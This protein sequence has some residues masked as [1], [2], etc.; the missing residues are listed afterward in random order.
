MA[1]HARIVL[2][3]SVGVS[4]GVMDL[5]VRGRRDLVL[6]LYSR[7]H[8]RYLMLFLSCCY[9]ITPSLSPAKETNSIG[10]G[11]RRPHHTVTL[12]TN[13]I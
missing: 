7:L 12:S 5:T 2:V 6:L 3:Q 4:T 13:H 1:G 9:P 8:L 11:L 10:L